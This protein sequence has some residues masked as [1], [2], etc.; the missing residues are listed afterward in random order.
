MDR[1]E[2]EVEWILAE[3]FAEAYG[4][5]VLDDEEEDG[6]TRPDGDEAPKRGAER[7]R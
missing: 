7:D 2:L 5:D 4:L 6:E 1:A 3:A